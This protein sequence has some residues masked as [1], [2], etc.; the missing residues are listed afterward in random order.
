MASTHMHGPAQEP[1]GLQL[2]GTVQ[3]IGSA[4]DEALTAAGGSL[5]TWMVLVSGIP[6]EHQARIGL[7]EV[8]LVTSLTKLRNNLGRRV[9]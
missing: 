2:V 5:R 3:L 7:S 1:L 6:Q 9:R 4:L 8:D